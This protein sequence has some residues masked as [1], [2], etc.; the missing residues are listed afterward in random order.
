MR[1]IY[2]LKSIADVPLQ[3][4]QPKEQPNA[5]WACMPCIEK[6]EPELANNI[7]EE[8]S[9]IEKDLEEICYPKN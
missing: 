9:D 2:C 8:Q 7:K 6:Q 5:G 1:C 3:R 4:T